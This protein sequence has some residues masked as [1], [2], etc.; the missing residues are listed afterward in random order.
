MAIVRPAAS[1]F[2]IGLDLRDGQPLV[3]QRQRHLL[4][5]LLDR[6]LAVD[7]AGLDGHQVLQRS[8][9]SAPRRLLSTVA[10]AKVKR[11]PSS[12]VKVMA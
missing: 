7:V 2:G 1:R 3:A 5:R 9:V 11:S 6:L 4:D 12:T 8:P 10:G